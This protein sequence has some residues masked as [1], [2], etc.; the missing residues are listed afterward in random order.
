MRKSLLLGMVASLGYLAIAASQDVRPLKAE[1]GLW[2]MT[3]TIVWSQGMPGMP[4]RRAHNYQS[5]VKAED[6][7]SNP[8]A[9]GSS[10]QCQWTVVTST[11]TDMDVKGSGCMLGMQGM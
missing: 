5:C 1:T 9:Q 6:L 11:A 10:A 8:W 7:K 4:N 2:Q 3:E